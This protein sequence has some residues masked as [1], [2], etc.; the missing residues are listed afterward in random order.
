MKLFIKMSNPQ[1]ELAGG[2]N[3]GLV[4]QNNEDNYIISDFGEFG[5]ILGVADG[6]GG[7]NA[8]EVASAIA[9]RTIQERFTPEQLKDITQS[10]KNILEF[11]KDIVKEADLNIF[12]HS[13]EDET[14]RGMGTTIVMA[15]ILGGKA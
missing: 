11:M 4:R 6:M 8:G 9:V 3:V 2:T 13:K 5:T 15:W 14:T 12:Q 7:E 10:D 1:I